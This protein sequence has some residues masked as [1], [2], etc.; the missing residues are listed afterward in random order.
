MKSEFLLTVI[1]PAYFEEA[2]IEAC[3]DALKIVMDENKWK[4]EFIFVNDGSKDQTLPLLKQ[5]AEKDRCVKV[6]DFARNFGHQVAV[7]AGIYHSSGDAT[8]VI[9][10]DLQDPPEVI[11]QMVEKWQEGYDV[12]YAKRKKRKGESWFKLVTAK[13]FYRFL[14]MMAEIEIPM[15]TG[16]F[17][18]IDRCVVEAFK[19]MPER[20]RFVRGMISWVG[21]DQTYIEYERDERLAGETKYPLKKMIRFATDG[22]IAFSTKPLKLVQS[23]GFMTIVLAILILGYSL[24]SKYILQTVVSGWT[25]L[26]VTI[27]FFSGVQLFSIGLLGEY[28]ARIY[29][30]SKNRP[31]YLIKEKINFEK[32]NRMFNENK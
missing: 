17:R 16:D 10:A 29:D 5:I 27:T 23:L 31:L 1:I 11:V 19:Q 28:I 21:F 6:I 20:N 25:S 15:D 13:C 30:E 26:M 9:D 8:V 32:E 2:V 22:I 14:H 7:T 3:Y 4:Y 12:V 18:L 24:V